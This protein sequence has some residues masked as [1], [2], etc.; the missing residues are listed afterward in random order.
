[1]P[2]PAGARVSLKWWRHMLTVTLNTVRCCFYF[3]DGPMDLRIIKQS[4]IYGS[5]FCQRL[6][7]SLDVHRCFGLWVR[8]FR[9]LESNPQDTVVDLK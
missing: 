3:P 8:F 2:L 6:K 9:G 5:S 1:M 7:L 4:L